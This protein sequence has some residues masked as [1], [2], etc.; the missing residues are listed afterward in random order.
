[1][2]IYFSLSTFVEGRGNE[3]SYWHASKGTGHLASAMVEIVKQNDLTLQEPQ[4]SITAMQ[5]FYA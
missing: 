1:M 3:I 4:S 2:E 5:I